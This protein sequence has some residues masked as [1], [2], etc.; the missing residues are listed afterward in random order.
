MKPLSLYDD[1]DDFLSGSVK[2]NPKFVKET[3]VQVRSKDSPTNPDCENNHELYTTG[4]TTAAVGETPNDDAKDSPYPP[5]RKKK[6]DQVLTA[7]RQKAPYLI[8]W[9]NKK[10]PWKKQMKRKK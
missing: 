4:P 9:R 3:R 8:W 7:V 10:Q 5:K 6:S 2:G 1:I